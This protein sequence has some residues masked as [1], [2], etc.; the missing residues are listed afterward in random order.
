M[1]STT[2]KTVGEIATANPS[3]ARVF[4]KHGIDYCCGG[5]RPFDL[6]RREKGLSAEQILAEVEQAKPTGDARDWAT[7]PLPE[8]ADHIV[9]THH[10]YL[11]AALPALDQR[12]AKVIAAHGPNHGDSLLPLRQTLQGLVEELTAH[13]MKEEMILFP[14][15][16]RIEAAQKAGAGLPGAHC[17]SVNNPIRVME[18]EHDSAANALREMRRVTGDYAL[19]ADACN[20]YRALFEGLQ[21]LETDLHLHI[22]LENNI[23]FPRASELEAC[24]SN[25]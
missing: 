19:P 12:L 21:E 14:L 17:G 16:K 8:L 13:M 18:Y 15:I 3:A 11:R 2:D 22:H 20:T 10:T 9:N 7:A 25:G 4:E 5:G 1:V 23:L 6:A 24:L